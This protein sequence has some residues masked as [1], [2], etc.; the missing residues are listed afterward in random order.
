MIDFYGDQSR[1]FIGVV[2]SVSDP[3]MMGRLQVR[4]HGIHGEDVDQVPD[5]NLPWAQ[6]LTPVTE[7]GIKNLGNFLGIQV[8]ARVFGIFLDGNN[9]QQPLILGSLP[10]SIDSTS[11]GGKEM[12][13]TTNVMAQ[14]TT[15]TVD[16][17]SEFDVA[18]KTEKEMIDEPLQKNIWKPVYPHNKVTQTSSGH[19]IEIDDTPDAER[20]H[21][22]HKSGTFIEMQP[23]GD[24]VTQHANGFRSVTGNDKLY[25]SGD[26]T[27]NIEGNITFSSLKNITF[28]AKENFN[29]VTDGAQDYSSK[30]NV[31]LNSEGAYSNTN[32]S[33]YIT[34]GP[35]GNVDIRG[36]K[37]DLNKGSGNSATLKDWEW[38]GVE[39]PK[40][41]TAG[42]AAETPTDDSGK[43]LGPSDPGGGPMKGEGKTGTTLSEPGDCTRKD[44]GS[45]SSRYESNNN[46]GAISGEDQKQT[47]GYS[48][49][50]YQISTKPGTFGTWMD[51]LK[52]EPKYSK[53]YTSLNNAGGTTAA[54]SG[55]TEF[56]NEWRNLAKDPDFGQ[57]QHDFI[58]RS[59]HDPA[60]KRIKDS[61]GI[62]VCDG[63]WSNGVQDAVWSTSVQHGV[64][65]AN[66]VLKNA[67]A[68]SGKTAD[69]IT[70]TELINAIYDERAASNG[71]KYFP[72][73]KSSVR[74]SVVDRFNN[75]ER[76]DALANSIKPVADEGVN[77][78]ISP[79]GAV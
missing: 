50:S 24:V 46:P 37:I 61:T 33:T 9:S 25:A 31:T 4:I 77:I 39:E 67:L 35:E 6:V 55:T 28:N 57:A 64:S 32:I 17:Y 22:Y 34:S 66:T 63:T 2:K 56:K 47:D 42:G 48:Y 7:G 53:Y 18:K 26:V 15:S 69:T 41:A 78:M 23:N 74:A 16:E 5:E 1:W 12:K 71:M 40:A 65:G 44:L 29:V 75:H 3:L 70:D 76:K 59:H 45:I 38:A 73:S 54:A 8:D 68:R 14:G 10:H 21:I 36:V 60:V 49:G 20:I 52:N 27:W 51:Y 11:T 13:V 58:Q 72:S 30:G 43:S 62:D 19:V 79:A